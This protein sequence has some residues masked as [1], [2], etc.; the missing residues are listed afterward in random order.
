MGPLL[1]AWRVITPRANP[2]LTFTNFGF[3]KRAAAAAEELVPAV[4]ATEAVEAANAAAPRPLRSS[5]LVFAD[6]FSLDLEKNIC[7]KILDL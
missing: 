6:P 2:G 1:P 7:Y 5:L 4:V 3:S